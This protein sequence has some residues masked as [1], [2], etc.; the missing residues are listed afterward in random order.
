[1]GDSLKKVPPKKAPKM[2]LSFLICALIGS[3]LGGICPSKEK[4]PTEREDEKT[5]GALAITKADVQERGSK[6]EGLLIDELVGIWDMKIPKGKFYLNPKGKEY[7]DRRIKLVVN[8]IDMINTH[9]KGKDL[10]EKEKTKSNTWL[11]KE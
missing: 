10:T 11:I 8:N 4:V 3:L 7:F 2:L 1:M 6:V 9:R 5:P